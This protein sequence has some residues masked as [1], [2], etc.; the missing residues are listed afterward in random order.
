MAS[1]PKLVRC[2][3]YTRKSSEEGLEQEFNSL[4]AQR[5]ACEAYVRSQKHEGWEALPDQYDDGGYS[6]GTLERPA[7][8]DLLNH[9]KQKKI[10]VVVVYKIDR[11]TRSLF[12]FSKIVEIFDAGGVSFVSVTQQFNTTTSMG[13]LTLNVL[14][15]FA[16][17]ER[18][19]TGERIR[20]KIAASKKKGMWMGGFVP[21]GYRAE[22]RTLVIDKGEAEIV[23]QIYD[24]YLHLQSIKAVRAEAAQLGFRT[25][26][27]AAGHSSPLSRG[28]IYRVLTNPIYMGKISH[29]GQLSKGLHDPIIESKTWEKVQKLLVDGSARDRDQPNTGEQSPLAGIIFDHKGELLTPSHAVKGGRRYR[30]YICQSLVTDKA[31]PDGIRLSAPEV[32]GAVSAAVRNLLND[33]AQVEKLFGSHAATPSELKQVIASSQE[34][35]TTISRKPAADQLMILRP[36]LSKVIIGNAD[37]CIDVRLKQ[38]VELL[39]KPDATLSNHSCLEGFRSDHRMVLPM[40]LGRRGNETRLILKSGTQQRPVDQ[41]LLNLI[42]RGFA[43]REELLSGAVE[44][45]S[46]IGGRDGI[47]RPYVSR[48]IDLSFLAPDIIAAIANGTAPADLSSEKLQSIDALPLGWASQRAVLGFGR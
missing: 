28:H 26:P 2:A 43:W 25:R 24:L 9:I 45:A 44:S 40:R 42:A 34:L 36:M 48:L 12:D 5:E 35:V 15:S 37:L 20:D 11:L 27:T 30:Y 21:L 29:K 19:V 31:K 14:L 1:S 7:L 41:K 46:D 4:D 6:G 22:K 18:E 13:R 38:L 47:S 16:Q 32:E 10:D 3:I 8:D 33:P 17:F 39:V 23:H